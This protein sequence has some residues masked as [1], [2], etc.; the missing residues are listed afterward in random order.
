MRSFSKH[1]ITIQSKSP[2]SWCINFDMSAERRFAVVV[3]SS[4][5]SV[6]KRVLGRTGSFS[7]MVLRMASMPCD[8]SSLASNGVLPASSS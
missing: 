8:I 7:R 4:P 2:L 5:L 6:A 1:F 3:N